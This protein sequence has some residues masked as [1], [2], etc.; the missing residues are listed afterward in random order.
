MYDDQ[1][2]Q[3]EEIELMRTNMQL[4]QPELIIDNDAIH[5][6]V[7][8][9][10]LNSD[11]LRD[12]MNA[13]VRQLV[14]QHLQLHV[15]NQLRLQQLQQA[16]EGGGQQQPG[17]PGQ[18][19]GKQPSGDGSQAGERGGQSPKNPVTRQQRAT[20]GQAAKPKRPQPSE[21]NQFH[22]QRLT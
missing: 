10:A 1:K 8:R 3:W 17:Q 16:A 4:I 22:R 5:I 6:D 20:K 11:D 14:K 7:C 18:Q 13:Q 21:G 2:V 15:M 19:P 9:Q 12:P